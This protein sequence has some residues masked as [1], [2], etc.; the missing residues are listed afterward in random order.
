VES[1]NGREEQFVVII[2]YKKSCLLSELAVVLVE[3]CEHVMS[4][5]AVQPLK[6]EIRSSQFHIEMDEIGRSK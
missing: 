4:C 5:D 3:A 2:T 1:I 6:L